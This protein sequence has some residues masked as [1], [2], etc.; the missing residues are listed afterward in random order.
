V[1]GICC[2]CGGVGIPVTAMVEGLRV[3][4]RIR[5]ERDG[6]RIEVGVFLGGCGPGY[7][8]TSASDIVL[9]LS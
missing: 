9:E 6:C 1:I 7:G 5:R 2:C 4:I 8:A 3:V